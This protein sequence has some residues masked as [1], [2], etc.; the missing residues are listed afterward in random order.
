[1]FGS[2]LISASPHLRIKRRNNLN[3]RRRLSHSTLTSITMASE[4]T[5]L[6]ALQQEYMDSS[7]AV[8]AD[9]GP[10]ERKAKREVSRQQRIPV[11]PRAVSRPSDPSDLQGRS[12]G[13][14]AAS[15][16][17]AV[18]QPV[19]QPPPRRPARPGRP[20]SVEMVDAPA[21]DQPRPTAGPKKRHRV[22]PDPRPKRIRER[23]PENVSE[24]SELAPFSKPTI[25]EEPTFAMLRLRRPDGKGYEDVSRISQA[26]QAGLRKWWG[27]FKARPDFRRWSEL[28]QWETKCC[29]CKVQSKADSLWPEGVY[30]CK[31]CTKVGRPCLRI[32]EVKSDENG[33]SAL[34]IAVLPAQ[35]KS[36]M[37]A[38]GY[39]K[40]PE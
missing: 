32:I 3:R 8:A 19:L 28:M 15:E 27:V 37:Q 9:A 29:G 38:F 18:E 39:W 7:G 26:E 36:T 23:S 11:A 4:F 30:A 31:T 25:V 24:L 33:E 16:E 22:T 13:P 6:K 40:D 2:Y 20:R 12:G 10:T 17:S 14:E 21:P 5:K 34:I 1:M 35:G